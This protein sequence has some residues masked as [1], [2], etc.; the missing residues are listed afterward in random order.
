MTTDTIF[1]L[2]SLSKCVGTATCVMILIDRGKI[3]PHEKVATYI[4]RVRQARQGR[5]HRRS[6]FS[7]TAA[8][9]SPTTPK[10]TTKTAP[11]KPGSA[12]A[13]CPEV[14]AR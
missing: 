7:S 9:S 5:H 8:A 14:Q 4:A 6:I 13:T 10:K 11:K 1:D 3:D 2:A 12:S